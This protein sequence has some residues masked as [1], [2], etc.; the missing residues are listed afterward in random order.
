MSGQRII[1][2][3]HG[4]SDVH[5]PSIMGT[6]L[7]RP[8]L[9][10]ALAL[11]EYYASEAV[12]EHGGSPVILAVEADEA[13]L[14]YDG[15]AMDEPVGF[16]GW[17]SS[18]LEKRVQRVWNYYARRRPEWVMNDIV[19]IP[20]TEYRISLGTVGSCRYAGQLP[21]ERVSLYE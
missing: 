21:A 11:G 4:T 10:R 13:S 1:K 5:L 15:A 7:Q 2:L 3:F 16:D 9:T 12:D 19:V 18:D 17:T 8:C 6:S 20:A 14:R